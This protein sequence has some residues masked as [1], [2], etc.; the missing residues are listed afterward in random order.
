MVIKLGGF[1]K[2]FSTSLKTWI[3]SVCVPI[4]LP[5]LCLDVGSASHTVGHD[6]SRGHRRV[7]EESVTGGKGWSKIF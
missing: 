6:R 7:Q 1:F 4:F 3:A 2:T 5:L